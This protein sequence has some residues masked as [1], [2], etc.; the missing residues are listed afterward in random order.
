MPKFIARRLLTLP[1]ILLLVTFI[2]FALM[3]QLPVEQRAKIYMPSIK[4]N[5][6]EEEVERLMAQIIARRGLDQP[7]YIQYLSWLRNLARGEWGYSPMW[8][9]DVLRGLLSR[10]PATLELVLAAMI[11]AVGLALLLGPLAARYEYR[12]PDQIIRIV[13]SVAWSFPAFILGLLL[14]N[15]FYAWLGWFPPERWSDWAGQVAQ[16]TSFRWYTRLYALDALLNGRLDLFVD[17]LRHLVL[18]AATLAVAQWALMTRVLRAA[19]LDALSQDYILAARAKGLPE[20][21][22]IARHARRNALLPLISMAGV[23]A[24]LLITGTVVVELVFS[25]PGVGRAA[26]QAILASDV[27]VAVGFAL[28]SGVITIVASLVA[29]VLYAVADPRVR[30]Y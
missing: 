12:L 10:A 4:P 1:A 7:A 25:Y 20:R 17:A 13:A 22:V 21:Y 6:S 24:S 26:V 18:P 5:A 14:M 28:F 11:P 29:D 8:R 2:L 19:T 3:W 16:S 30:L 9:Q 15:V 23:A 27:P